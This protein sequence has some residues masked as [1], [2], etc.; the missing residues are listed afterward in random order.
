[1]SGLPW[2]FDVRAF[3][4][5]QQVICVGTRVRLSISW[6][7]IASNQVVQQ[8]REIDEVGV[9]WGLAFQLNK[10]ELKS[11]ILAQIER[12]RRA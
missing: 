6:A 4:K 12:W 11:L 8:C 9:A 3:F 1:M 10:F 2:R 5:K 7:P